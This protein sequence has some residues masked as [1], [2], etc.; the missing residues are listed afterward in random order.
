[1]NKTVFIITFSFLN[2]TLRCDPHWN[3]L[4]ETIPMSGNIIGFGQ[5]IR[6]LA[7]WKLS[8]LDLILLPW[9]YSGNQCLVLC[10]EIPHI[11]ALIFISNASFFHFSMDP[12][13]WQFVGIVSSRHRI[14]WDNRKQ[15]ACV[16]EIKCAGLNNLIS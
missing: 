15:A 5:E 3:R 7:F 2:Q 1:M 11:I 6:K 9:Q 14:C 8:I 10:G 12:I 16:Y 13:L 4:S